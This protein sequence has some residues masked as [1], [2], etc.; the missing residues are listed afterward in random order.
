[1]KKNFTGYAVTVLCGAALFAVIL[2]LHG[3]FTAET[4]LDRYRILCDAFTIPGVIIIMFGLLF[5]IANTGALDGISYAVRGL[6]RQL[7]PFLRIQNEKFYDYV[8]R[9]SAKRKKRSCAFLFIT[10]AAFLA[11]AVVFLILF[12]IN[13]RG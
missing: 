1:M 6:G 9:K 8:Q 7:I 10:G 13:Y 4:V 2:V 3:F 5:L 11:A 12:E